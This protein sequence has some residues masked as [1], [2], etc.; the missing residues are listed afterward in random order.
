MDGGW[1]LSLAGQAL[2]TTRRTETIEVAQQMDG[3]DNKHNNGRSAKAFFIPDLSPSHARRHHHAAPSKLSSPAH[4]TWQHHQSPSSPSRTSTQKPPHSPIDQ[5]NSA[6]QLS[7]F[8][9]PS[10]PI[11]RSRIQVRGTQP[12]H[13]KQLSPPQ[14]QLPTPLPQRAGSWDLPSGEFDQSAPAGDSGAGPK[15]QVWR[16]RVAGLRCVLACAGLRQGKLAQTGADARSSLGAG[17]TGGA[18]GGFPE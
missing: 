10:Q 12:T 15:R 4:A 18:L 6:S 8:P 16:D 2:T 13:H 7:K 9:A 3:Q 11:H 1:W 14:L 5:A 17:W